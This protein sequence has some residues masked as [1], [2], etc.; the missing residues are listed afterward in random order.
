MAAVQNMQIQCQGTFHA[1]WPDDLWLGDSFPVGLV[2]PALL[3]KDQI[4]FIDSEK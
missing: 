1:L 4:Y 3:F 2:Y